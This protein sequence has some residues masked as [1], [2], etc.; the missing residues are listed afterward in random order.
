MNEPF[1]SPPPR[2]SDERSAR[3]RELRRIGNKN[4]LLLL[5]FFLLSNLLV[6]L[7]SLL[8]TPLLREL[9]D[10]SLAQSLLT[11]LAF[12][13]QYLVAVPILLLLNRTGGERVRIPLRK[14]QMPAGKIAKWCL[15]AF[16][17]TYA[18]NYVVSI[19]FTILEGMG[20]TLSAPSLVLQPT[21]LDNLITF[22]FFGLVAPVCEELFFRGALLANLRRQGEW[23]AIVMIG[24]LF[25]LM[26]MNYQQIFYAAALGIFAG[27]L[28]RKADSV[29]PAI[30][31]HFLLNLVGSI[32]SI[33][34]SHLDLAEM[35]AAMG[36]GDLVWLSENI[37]RMMGLFLLA[38]V[39]FV[40]SILGVVLLGIELS[41]R[42]RSP[43]LWLPNDCPQLS[44]REKAAAYLTA[45][46]TLAF[47]LLA[48]VMT[49]LSA[50]G[51]A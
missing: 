30:L 39:C 15:I 9:P 38:S 44:A 43:E 45:P 27:F 40:L 32:Q 4:G 21:L 20:I 12:V 24:V 18:V 3:R 37:W 51:I 13:L 25:G 5:G 28:C 33:L 29:Y 14:P 1:S 8:L 19:F 26:H 6:L 31:V 11:L 34:L 35:D 2:P 50:L 16:G 36:N 7:G 17:C 23:F 10:T 49:V 47:L 48:V 41:R 42:R 22:V 46:G